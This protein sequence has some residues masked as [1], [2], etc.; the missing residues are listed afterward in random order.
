[1]SSGTIFIDPVLPY[2]NQLPRDY[3]LKQKPVV[4]PTPVPTPVPPTPYP[5]P[6]PPTTE[7][8]PD[9]NL[10][11][12]GPWYGDTPPNSPSYGWL[13]V[14][15]ANNGLYVY[16]DPGVWTQVGTNW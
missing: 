12:G 6:I 11:I 3:A 7:A 15:P 4:V 5:T 16:T 8:V 13:W 1:M 9:I 2:M 10:Q 14:N